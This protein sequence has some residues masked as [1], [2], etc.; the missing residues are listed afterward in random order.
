MG[1]VTILLRA[2][3]GYPHAD[4][5][6][7]PTI[8]SRSRVGLGCH[9]GSADQ[10]VELVAAGDAQLRVGAVQVRGDGAR[11]QEQPVG[12]LTVGVALAGQEDDLALLGG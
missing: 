6:S 3:A 7:K 5:T 10:V 12:D 4:C 11:R 9:A 2:A 1:R 8:R